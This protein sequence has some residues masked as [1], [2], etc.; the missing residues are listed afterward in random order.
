[1]KL[2]D[3]EFCSICNS[4]IEYIDKEYYRDMYIKILNILNIKTSMDNRCFS[5]YNKIIYFDDCRIQ[6][7][8]PLHID[9]TFLDIKS[10]ENILNNYYAES[11]Y[12]LTVGYFF[13]NLGYIVRLSDKN[14]SLHY[15]DP[16]EEYED[17]RIPQEETNIPDIY[18]DINTNELYY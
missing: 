7:A 4:I 18:T 15:I 6:N 9:L 14:L 11:N 10:I 12:T 16:N 17:W 13:Y 8:I 3:D 2:T 1:M 5:Y